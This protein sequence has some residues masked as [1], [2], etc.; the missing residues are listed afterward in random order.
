MLGPLFLCV[1]S[2]DQRCSW[3]SASVSFGKGVNTDRVWLWLE[4]SLSVR[5]GAAFLNE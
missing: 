5:R 4:I 2:N 1:V 3:L